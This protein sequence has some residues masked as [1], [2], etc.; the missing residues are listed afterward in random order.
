MQVHFRYLKGVLL[1]SLIFGIISS[2]KLSNNTDQEIFYRSDLL[3]ITSHGQFYRFCPQ[4][5]SRNI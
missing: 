2:F 4:I 3:I 1:K 5:S